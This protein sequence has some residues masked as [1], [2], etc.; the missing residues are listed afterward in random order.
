MYHKTNAMC[1]PLTFKKLLFFKIGGNLFDHWGKGQI[2]T[3]AKSCAWNCSHNCVWNCAYE[4][5][6]PL[7]ELST[8]ESESTSEAEPVTGYFVPGNEAEDNLVVDEQHEHPDVPKQH[9]V[10]L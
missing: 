2:E 3:R 7:W 1:A 8:P 5:N 4:S 9:S 6:R 10:T